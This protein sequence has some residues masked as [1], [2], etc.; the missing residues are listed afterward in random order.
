MVDVTSTIIAAVSLFGT[1][2]IGLLNLGYS[3]STD[4]WKRH[5]ES[6]NLIA[7]YRDPLLLAAHD[8]QSRLYNI[9]D[10]D[11]YSWID[12]TKEK[13]ENLRLYTTFLVG[14]FLSWVYILRRQAQFLR[15]A[16]STRDRNKRLATTLALISETFSTDRRAWGL[17]KAGFTLWRGQ[18]TGIGEIMTTED[19]CYCLGYAGFVHKYK[20][21]TSSQQG[22]VEWE[23]A[24]GCTGD[25]LP[26]TKKPD[27]LRVASQEF[28][29][30]FRPLIEGV[31]KVSEA[32]Q[33][34]EAAA[35]DQRMRMLQ[36]LM[37]ELMEVLDVG[38]AVIA[39]QGTSPCRAARMC[40]CTKCKARGL[41]MV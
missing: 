38:G 24:L 2:A 7:K 9:V 29:K 37:L 25:R 5:V 11:L 4:T 6:E 30:W 40:P 27:G 21:S 35:L 16:S 1:L 3:W 41:R 14:Q 8:L 34:N 15:F 12:G 36:H 26:K 18:Q 13:K 20:D 31:N 22:A 10:G 17:D 39:G 28:R 23:L 19:E 33:A 32:R